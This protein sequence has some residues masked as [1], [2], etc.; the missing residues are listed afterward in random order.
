MRERWTNVDKKYYRKAYVYI[1]MGQ[2]FMHFI[3]NLPGLYIMIF[4]A[5]QGLIWLDY[6]GAI[7]WTIGFLIEV[8]A[9]T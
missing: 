1:F 2:A 9:D 6:V 8:I 5:D 4:A 3:T 7:I